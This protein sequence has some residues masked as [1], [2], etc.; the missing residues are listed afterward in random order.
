M[1]I[2]DIVIIFQ[3]VELKKQLIRKRIFTIVILI[4][5]TEKGVS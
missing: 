2:K 3:I 5:K 4:K 1:Q